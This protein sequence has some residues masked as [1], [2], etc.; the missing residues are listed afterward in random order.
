MLLIFLR[1]VLSVCCVQ[2]LRPPVHE[3]RLWNSAQMHHL[4]AHSMKGRIWAQFGCVA[5][6]EG[7][8]RSLDCT[9]KESD[10]CF[11]AASFTC[12]SLALMVPHAHLWE[13]QTELV[14]L[15]N[16]KKE[17]E[18]GWVGK[19]LVLGEVDIVDKYDHSTVNFI[20]LQRTNKY[21]GKK[22]FRESSMC[23]LK[24]LPAHYCPI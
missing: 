14:V 18:V 3:I 9:L 7:C 12:I 19:W 13:A 4:W 23:F 11:P 1:T 22:N 21:E 15:K 5:F 10:S 6:T 16:R 20:Y 2:S 17:H 24:I 8:L